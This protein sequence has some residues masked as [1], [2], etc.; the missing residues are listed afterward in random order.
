MKQTTDREKYIQIL[1]A[2]RLTGL[3]GTDIH[4]LLNLGPWGCRRR[5]WYQKRG[6]PPD[7][8]DEVRPE[9]ER[10]VAL[11][12][13]VVRRYCE[14]TNSEDVTSMLWE[15]GMEN[16][17]TGLI[18][19]REHKFLI[20]HV[21]AIVDK[22]QKLAVLEA[23]TAGQHM[24]WKIK[25][26]GLPDAYMLQVQ[27]AMLVT[28]IPRG[29]F[30]LLWP[31]GWRFLHFQVKADPKI[32]D[33]IR[34]EAADF[35]RILKTMPEVIPDALA[36]TDPRCAS[37][38]WRSSCQGKAMLEA[39]RAAGTA[40][41]SSLATTVKLKPILARYHNLK[42]LRDESADMFEAAA[43]ELRDAL[44][45]ANLVETDD[46]TIH[47]RP[48][49][50]VRVDVKKLRRRYPDVAEDCQVESVSR[51]LRVMPK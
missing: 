51:P 41:V 23:K 43:D 35:W 6:I 46:D 22:D 37:C 9:M 18:R 39:A 29:A 5:L 24:Y 49:V 32:Q 7:F 34:T 50:S 28:G 31:D 4:Q 16:A 30:A 45:E 8:E 15:D 2:E 11:E 10:G 44:G 33:M 21:D 25:R 17:R 26:D 40:A 36:P 14:E 38:A 48:V 27:H 12:S 13:I 3:G 19:H 20:S 1:Q 47:F 42:G